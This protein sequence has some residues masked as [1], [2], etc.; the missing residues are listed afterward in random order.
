MDDVSK[1]SETEKQRESRPGSERRGT[2]Y[3]EKQKL[4]A[5]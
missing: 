1:F 3:G 2:K 5:Y 4:P